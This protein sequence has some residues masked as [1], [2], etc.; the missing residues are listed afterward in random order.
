LPYASVG[1][2]AQDIV[3]AEEETRFSTYEPPTRASWGYGLA[4]EYRP[5]PAPGSAAAFGIRVGVNRLHPRLNRGFEE[6]LSGA[7]TTVT[8]G[9]AARLETRRRVR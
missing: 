5:T 9:M 8:V 4:L 6:V 1:V 2:L 3:V 7:I